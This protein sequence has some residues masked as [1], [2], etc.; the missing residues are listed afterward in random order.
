[1]YNIYSDSEIYV[2]VLFRTDLDSWLPDSLSTLFF[3]CLTIS[4]ANMDSIV[5]QTVIPQAFEILLS[6]YDP[7]ASP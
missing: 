2:V 1:M 3:R 6:R 4:L 5:E 7:D